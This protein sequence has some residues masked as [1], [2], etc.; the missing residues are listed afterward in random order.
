MARLQ[1]PA[2]QIQLPPWTTVGRSPGSTIRIEESQVSGAH[3][4]IAWNGI[5][6]TL[7]DLSSKN[8]TWI[9]ERRAEPGQR[10]LLNPG[11]RL[12]FGPQ[13]EPHEVVDVAP[14]VARAAPVDG[15]APIEGTA[16][17]LGIPDLEQPQVTALARAEGW[18]LESEGAY[19][20]VSDGHELE[21]QGRRWRLE[22]PAPLVGTVAASDGIRLD[23]L[24]LRFDVSADEEHVRITVRHDGGEVDLPHRA[25]HYLLLT[26]ARARLK[27]RS[28]GAAP[29]EEGWEDVERLAR[30]LGMTGNAFHVQLFR[31]RAQLGALGVDDVGGIFERRGVGRVRLGV[32]RLDV[33]RAA[34]S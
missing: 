29:A 19:A 26:L 12:R 32:A 33:C 17:L 27:D 16:Q 5:G 34:E 4:I 9:D 21:V 25:H 24:A 28:R 11:Q 13:G 15:G 22:L 7:H 6:W 10:V 20:P 23:T 3:A 1:T 14:P 8:G 18:M 30:R 31:A 2:G